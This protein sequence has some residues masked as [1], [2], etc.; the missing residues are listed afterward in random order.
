MLGEYVGCFGSCNFSWVKELLGM[1]ARAARLARTTVALQR[2]VGMRIKDSICDGYCGL[3]ASIPAKGKLL[4]EM[5]PCC[6]RH[7]LDL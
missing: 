2:I 6:R 3:I 1:L 4:G 5:L 7:V